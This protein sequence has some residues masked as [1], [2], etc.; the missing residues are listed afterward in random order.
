[1]RA[2]TAY[3][4]CLLTLQIGCSRAQTWDSVQS[5]ID[6]KYPDVPTIS[7]DSL[8]ERL[9][10]STQSQPLLLDARSAEEY[11]VSH[12]PG[13]RRID[14]TA[15]TF[16]A[17]DTLSA[18]HPIVVYCS[19]GYR[20][21]RIASRLQEKGFRSVSNLQGSI[22]RWANEGRPVVRNGTPVQEVHPY[23]S[24]WGS[25][26]DDRLHKYNPPSGRPE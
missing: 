15:T 9:A 10:D 1:M 6:A 16:P 26:L 20:S 11:A 13:A 5:M 17:L 4:L 2:F 22:F 12:V 18:D 7:T 14:P 21:A 25:L 19:V 3:A 24:T 8:A 23:S